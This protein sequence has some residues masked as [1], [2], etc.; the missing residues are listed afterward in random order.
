M[1]NI[2]ENIIPEDNKAHDDNNAPVEE[3][4]KKNSKRAL[5]LLLLL[6]LLGSLGYTYYVIQQGQSSEKVLMDEKLLL[7]KELQEL[8]GNYDQA[9]LDNA[10]VSDE[11]SLEKDKVLKLMD[12]LKKSN[13]EI[14]QL[15]KYR[16]Q[17]Q[18]L[19]MNMSQL[20]TENQVLATI[21][22]KFKTKVDS[23]LIELSKAEIRSKTLEEQVKTLSKTVEKGSVVKPTGLTFQA[24]SQR[25]SSKTK[26]EAYTNRANKA[27]ELK[28][29]FIVPENKIA[30]K[31]EF[32]FYVQV[33]DPK[34]NILGVKETV[35]FKEK[36]LTYS[37]EKAVKYEN[38]TIEI[39]EY[40]NVAMMKFQ[41]GNYTAQLFNKGDFFDCP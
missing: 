32:N 28:V 1:S 26:R 35:Y 36:S 20:V 13:L 41:K 23:S 21:N 22:T 7:M 33:S 19:K 38:E 17:A 31:G 18:E 15:R 29:C 27:K 12:E 30:K 3:G 5:I 10:H 34:N 25:L 11:L 2:D 39:C 16:S 4:K 9:I 6:L 14:G 8:K 37:F 24:V 40:I